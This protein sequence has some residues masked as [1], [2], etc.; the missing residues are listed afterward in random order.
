[1]R[2]NGTLGGNFCNRVLERSRARVFSRFACQ[3]AGVDGTSSCTHLTYLQTIRTDKG[4]AGE[5]DWKLRFSNSCSF[6]A[7]CTEVDRLLVDDRARNWGS[8]SSLGRDVGG[9]WMGAGIVRDSYVSHEDCL[10]FCCHPVSFDPGNLRSE[11]RGSWDEG[12]K[13]M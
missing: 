12:L 11:G 3:T 2:C 1:M 9:G 6:E 4:W 8:T 5:T 7:S 13:M 10:P